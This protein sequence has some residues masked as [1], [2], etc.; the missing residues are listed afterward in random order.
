M[1]FAGIDLNLQKQRL[2]G[3]IN[4]VLH[5]PYWH[6]SELLVSMNFPQILSTPLT[7]KAAHRA[8]FFLEYPTQFILIS[9]FS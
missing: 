4:I 8:A 1:G 9:R 3:T 6:E 2:I 5:N 7:K